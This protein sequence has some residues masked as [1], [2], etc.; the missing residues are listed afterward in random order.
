M[1]SCALPRFQERHHDYVL[2]P[3]QDARLASVAAGA[4]ITDIELQLDPDAPFVLRSRA[5]RQKYTST[6]T[7]GGLSLLKTKWTGPQRGDFRQQDYI[8]ESLQM[9]YYGQAGNPKPVRPS[10]TYPANGILAI[11]LIN[12]SSS[13]LTNL[14]F[15][16]RGVK[17]FPW[18][19]VPAYRYPPAMKGLTFSYPVPIKTLGVSEK[20]TNLIFQPGMDN[21]TGITKPDSDFVLRAGQADPP[22][23]NAGES[24]RQFAEVGIRLYDWNKKPYSN[25]FVPLDVIFGSGNF[26]LVFPTGSN[27]AAN[28]VGPFGTGPGQPGLFYPEIYVPRLNQLI[29]DIQRTDGAVN[30]NQSES[31]VINFIGQKVFPQ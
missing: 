2:G 23:Q 21:S 12:T 18:G 29:Y 22:F 28:L 13:A 26:P 25:D 1:T 8:L 11:N 4:V 6:L 27:A 14:T 24:I 30:L 9:A 10:I 20:R 5:V 15:F 31:F 17:L 19:S 7:Q 3:N 16:W